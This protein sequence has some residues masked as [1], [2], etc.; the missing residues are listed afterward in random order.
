MVVSARHLMRLSALVEQG[1][2]LVWRSCC[3][4]INRKL[5]GRWSDYFPT[6]SSTVVRWC[7]GGT[8]VR[9]RGLTAIQYCK[10][11]QW[12]HPYHSFKSPREAHPY[13][14]TCT[15]T[16][17]DVPH[18]RGNISS[19]WLAQASQ[20]IDQTWIFWD[21]LISGQL[22][23]TLFWAVCSPNFAQSGVPCQCPWHSSS[24]SGIVDRRAA[25][26][27]RRQATFIVRA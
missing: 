2:G 6:G 15:C 10:A 16:T 11:T 14:T 7:S 3:W 20:P 24:M 13:R 22:F 9:I 12:H 21:V 5:L 26:V 23:S 19:W 8:D 1:I 17:A 18:G 27:H 25:N 4:I